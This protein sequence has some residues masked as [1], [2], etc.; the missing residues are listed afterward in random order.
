[1][2]T[3]VA[4]GQKLKNPSF[5]GRLGQSLTPPDWYPCN[6]YSTPDTQPGAWGV[7]KTAFAGNSYLS[8]TTRGCCGNINDNTV[9]AIGAQFDVPLKL[10]TCYDMS[11]QMAYSTQFAFSGLSYLP[12][13]LKVYLSTGECAKDKLIWTSP[14]VANTDWQIYKVNFSTQV[15]YTTIILEATFNGANTHFGN[16]LIDDI[17]ISSATLDLGNDRVLCENEK[18]KLTSNIQE[19]LFAWSTGA[20]APTL[21]VNSPGLYWLENVNGNCILRDSIIVTRRNPIQIQLA[22]TAY[23][24]AEEELVLDA[25]SPDATSYLWTTGS[26]ESK[27]T[28]TEAGEYGVEITGYCGSVE[29]LVTVFYRNSCCEIS[30]PNVFTP[31]GDR[32]NEYFEIGTTFNVARFDLKIFN[33][34]GKEVFHTNEPLQFWDGTSNGKEVATGIYYWYVTLSC[35]HHKKIIDNTFKGSVSVLR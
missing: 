23:L 30:A 18:V 25:H 27:I 34:W 16:L 14:V 24:C 29:E 12:V 35:I 17:R 22:D 13:K 3:T 2:W 26:R 11:F 32:W 6:L 33:S 1:M 31:N 28:V 9:E 20:R 15:P 5:E 7:T 8:L 4:A 19:G 21:E 10:N